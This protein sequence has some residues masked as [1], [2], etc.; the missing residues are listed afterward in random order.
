MNVQ[1]LYPY[2]IKIKIVYQEFKLITISE[3]LQYIN[4]NNKT[5]KSR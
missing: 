4:D 1:L 3:E 5:A 2:Q